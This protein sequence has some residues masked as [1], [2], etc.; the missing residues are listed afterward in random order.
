MV[1]ILFVIQKESALS[2]FVVASFVIQK[3]SLWCGVINT[4]ENRDSY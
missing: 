4:P 2:S 3:E 1:C